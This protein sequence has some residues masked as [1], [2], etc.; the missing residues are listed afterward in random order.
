MSGD[1]PHPAPTSTN[2][3]QNRGW[4]NCGCT[5]NARLVSASAWL[6]LPASL[7]FHRMLGPQ[8]VREYNRSLAL[9][10]RGGGSPLPAGRKAW[11]VAFSG[12]LLAILLVLFFL[13]DTFLYR[14]EGVVQPDPK[15]NSRLRV[16]G[17]VN[18]VLL[19]VAVGAIVLSGIWKPGVGVA[20]L[21]TRLE[22]QN[23]L[24]EATMIAVGLAS[25]T[26]GVPY[27]AIA[28]AAFVIGTLSAI[29]SPASMTLA[30][31]LVPPGLVPSAMTLVWLSVN[32]GRVAGGALAALTLAILP[33]GFTLAIAGLVNA[34]VLLIVPGPL[35]AA[36]ME[37]VFV[38]VAA[39]LG[40]CHVN[41][42]DTGSIAAPAGAPCASE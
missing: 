35:S 27:A 37:I 12:F 30:N 39:S 31:D 18:F 25:V 2:G 11:M 14:R 15:T 13:I 33:G 29:G 21:G 32:I 1:G 38:S 36:T 16:T 8:R 23:L 3:A 5:A 6:A 42:P 20:I 19:A 4:L 24:R 9:A 22:L 41:W 10:A 26:W 17:L 34:L 28:G 40:V 7:D